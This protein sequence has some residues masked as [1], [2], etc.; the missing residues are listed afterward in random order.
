MQMT[1]S[2]ILLSFKEAKDPPRQIN[3]LAELNATSV[4]NIKRI[5]LDCGVD[6]KRLP[7]GRPKATTR[8]AVK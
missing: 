7:F 8:R 5:L 1:D 2:E 3:I 4:A 6:P